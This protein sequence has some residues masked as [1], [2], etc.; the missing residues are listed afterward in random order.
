MRIFFFLALVLS[1]VACEDP[2]HPN[3][4]TKTIHFPNSEAVKQTVDYKNGKKNGY[5][6]EYY[7]D[8]TLKASQYY[9]NDT[10]DDTT[11]IYHPDRRLKTIQ[12][13]KDKRRHGVW[14]DYNKSGGLYS[15]ISFQD[16][17]LHGPSAQYT[18]R[19]LKP[20]TKTNYHFGVKD[21]WEE[22]FYP[23]GR[24]RCKVYYDKGVAGN[25]LEE[26]LENGTKI[27]NDFEISVT[28]R[29]ETL[30]NGLLIYY[31]R[32]ENPQPDDEVL[33]LVNPDKPGSGFPLKKNG[34]VFAL[35]IPVSKGSFVMEKVTIAAYRKTAFNN[36]FV[37]TKIFNAA[38]DN[39]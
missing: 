15:E 32:L 20:K 12:I 3:D 24:P 4:G 14:R 30:L 9:V 18:Y 19:T 17:L 8:G 26:W 25:G 6:K 28:E 7:R 16:G 22:T 5:L 1:L 2:E 39:F 36:T 27:E 34:D 10:L 23:N 13:Y 21:G 37:K 33:H 35:E 31:I 11:R 38:S 29:N